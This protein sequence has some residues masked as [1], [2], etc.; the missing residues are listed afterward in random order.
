MDVDTNED[1]ED[2]ATARTTDRMHYSTVLIQQHMYKTMMA[3]NMV[4]YSSKKVV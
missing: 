3:V 2:Y 4:N 1:D